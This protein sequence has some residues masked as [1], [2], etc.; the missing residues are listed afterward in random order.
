MCRPDMT[1]SKRLVASHL[2][3]KALYFG[4]LPTV[5][6]ANELRARMVLAPALV[7]PPFQGV[8]DVIHEPGHIRDA[9]VAY[10]RAMQDSAFTTVTRAPKSSEEV[11]HR[12]LCSTVAG[13]K[14]N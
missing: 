5:E 9:H 11:I 1:L 7:T 3:R 2:S 13:K 10:L 12:K 4:K 8:S 6:D 14:G